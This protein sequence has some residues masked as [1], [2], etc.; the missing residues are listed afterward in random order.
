MKEQEDK[1]SKRFVYTAFRI[2]FALVFTIVGFFVWLRNRP[3][4]PQL[5]LNALISSCE[6]ADLAWVEGSCYDFDSGEDF[7][8]ICSFA[9]W[10]PLKK[11]VEGEHILSVKL[12]DEYEVAFYSCGAVKAYFGYSGFGYSD[13]AWYQASDD[14]VRNAVEFVR[15]HGTIRQPLLGAGAWFDT[16]K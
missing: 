13:T 9:E 8:Q 6:K 11:G 14:I 4:A 3:I 7:G 5:E 10:M 15:T 12:A 16:V 1:I 2:F